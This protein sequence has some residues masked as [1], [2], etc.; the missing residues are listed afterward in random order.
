M[1]GYISVATY[2]THVMS[3]TTADSDSMLLETGQK[4]PSS[5]T[6]VFFYE[7]PCSAWLPSCLI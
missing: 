3:Y 5:E 7:V 2:T 6:T 4:T 1:Y